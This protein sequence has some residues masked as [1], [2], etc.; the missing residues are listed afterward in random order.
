MS[1]SHLR[2]SRVKVFTLTSGAT[3]FSQGYHP[4]ETT[5]APAIETYIKYIRCQLIVNRKKVM[6]PSS[7]LGL[8]ME[9][10]ED[11]R[12]HG[13]S[14]G[15]DHPIREPLRDSQYHEPKSGCIIFNPK[16]Y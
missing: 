13:D 6:V 11:F 10:Y 2:S 4:H 15:V 16:T 14:A 3:S 1:E 7:S 5:K 9:L 8:V 12:T